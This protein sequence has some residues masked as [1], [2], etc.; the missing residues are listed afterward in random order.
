MSKIAF[1]LVAALCLSTVMAGFPHFSQGDPRWK[2]QKLGHGPSTIGSA[3]C[4]LTSVTSMI[5]GKG[6]KVNGA[7]P[8][9]PIMNKWLKAH[10]GFSRD[11]FIWG[12]IGKLGFKFLGKITNRN[13]MVKAMNA[14]KLVILN[15]NHGR[16][17]VLATGHDKTGFKVMD[18]GYSKTHY[19]F[20]EVVSASLY[21]H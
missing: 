20:S 7:S 4:L 19:K 12:S 8:T 11:N 16:H 17:Y 6:V 3:G 15:V 1:V 5:A 2:S 10:G 21:K 18:P 13:E 9:P 14:G